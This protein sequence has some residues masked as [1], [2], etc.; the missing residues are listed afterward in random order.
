MVNSGTMNWGIMSLGWSPSVRVRTFALFGLLFCASEAQLWAGNP[1][2]SSETREVETSNE[3]KIRDLRNQEVTQLRIA[4]GRR[5]PVHR[6]AELYFRL[7]EIYLEA[8]RSE[9]LLEGRVHDKRLE[10]GI[11]DKIIDRS[12]SKPHLLAGIRAC[13][14]IIGFHIPFEKMDQVYYF[15]GFYY[16]ELDERKASAR[17]YENL[18]QSYPN[19]VFSG[20]A[21]KELGDYSFYESQFSKSKNYYENALRKVSSESRAPILHKLAWSYYRTRQ[22][23]RAV[24]TLKD[25]VAQ[26]NQYPE[27]YGP[28]KDE[29]LRDMAIFMTETGRVE[30]AI[31]YFEREAGDKKLFPKILE[32]LGLLYE[33]N[34]ELAKAIVV[35]ESLLKTHPES[36]PAFRVLI[37]LIELDVKQK[38]FPRALQR[39]KGF[40]VPSGGDSETQ[41]AAQNVKVLIRKIATDHHQEYRKKKTTKAL[42]VAEGFYS[43]YLDVFLSKEDPHKEIPEIRMYLAEVKKELGKTK[44]VAALYRQVVASK[45]SRYAKEAG[46]L[47][48]ASLA[49]AM[50]QSS[51]KAGSEPSALE[52]EF[53]EAADFLQDSIGDTQEAKEAALRAAQVQAGYPSTYSNAIDRIQAILTQWP[54]SKQALIAAQLRIQL[55]SDRK[56]A[57]ADSGELRE[58]IEGLKKNSELMEFDRTS[59]QGKLKASIEELENTAKI[60]EIAKQERDQDYRAAAKG[61]LEFAAS[62]S[63]KDAAEKAYGNAMSSYLK[64]GNADDSMLELTALWAKRY[65]QSPKA[66]ES[67]RTVATNALIRGKFEFSTRIFEKLGTEF[68]NPESLETAARLYEALGDAGRAQQAWARYLEMYPSSSQRWHVA[69]SLARSQEA[70][71]L[72]SEASRSYRT[73]ATGSGAYFAECNSRLADLYLKSRNVAQAKALFKQV[74]SQSAKKKSET[75]SPYVGYARYKLADLAESEATFEP[76]RFPESQLQKALGQRLNF[77]EPLSQSY[78]SA[79]QVGG[80]WALAS[81]HRLAMWATHFADEVDAIEPPASLQGPSLEKFRRDLASVS[82][83]LREKAR[84][85]W[86][87]SYQKAV[88]F[89]LLSPVLPEVADHLADFQATLPARAQGPKGRYSLSGISPDGGE[90]GRNPAYER[91][92]EKLLK[93]AQDG[94]AWVD[95][96][97]L[98]WGEGKPLL[99]RITYERALSLNARNTAALNNLAVVRLKSEGEENWVVVIESQ[100]LFEN[101]LSGDDFFIPSK[102][103]LAFLLNYYRLFPKAKQLWDQVLVKFPNQSDAEDGFGVALQ[104]TGNAIAAEGAFRKATDLGANSSRFVARYHEAARHSTRGR[105]GA[106]K[107]VDLLGSISGDWQGFEL[108]AAQYL[109]D[110]CELWKRKK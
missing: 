15:L 2:S 73:C 102:I 68:R 79:V 87:E 86:N 103:N 12:H 81:L 7:A 107:C 84:M 42:P 83:P 110:Q 44:E 93:N 65:P 46:I 70:S 33:R 1:Y 9:F 38:N 59:N 96:G 32:K 106:E 5:T 31:R 77:L 41:T 3:S 34:V 35:Y 37:K 13:Q 27:K 23:D 91:T 64:D 25:S 71:Q 47:W 92:R 8:Y 72:E 10:N 105:D 89:N 55:C 28:L 19:S 49:E 108:R 48:T 67:L 90:G 21:Y 82:R 53:I 29:A 26:C 80:P 52:K 36:E 76:L 78:Q 94:M 22:F 98:L 95:Y 99:A 74:A 16:G 69:L 17:Y 39:L 14:E 4:L 62:T 63:Q 58:V 50:K 60:S 20:M 11:P 101:A 24:T 45:D 57:K 40:T 54:K 109:K 43:A 56:K 85:T 6:K 51:Q 88:A 18:V 97:N 66:M 75:L 104:G 100:R 30:E 61:Y